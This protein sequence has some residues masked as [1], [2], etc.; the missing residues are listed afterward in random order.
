MTYVVMEA[1]GG[2][3]LLAI[4]DG[5]ATPHALIGPHDLALRIR[6]LLNRHGHHDAPIPS[7]DTS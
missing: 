3:Q 4:T 7:I 6:D 2:H 5:T 1:Y